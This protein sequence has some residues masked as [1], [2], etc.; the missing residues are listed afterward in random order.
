[1]PKDDIVY[2]GHMLD[3]TRKAV[4][5]VAGRSMDDFE[6]DE[7][8]RLVVAHLIQTIGE[9]AA[10]VSPA[11]RQAI[12]RFRGTRS[13]AFGTTSFMATCLSTGGFSGEL[14]PVIYRR[15]PKHSNE[16]C[17]RMSRRSTRPADEFPQALQ[18]QEA[19][20]ICDRDT[21]VS[22]SRHQRAHSPDGSQSCGSAPGCRSNPRISA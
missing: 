11:M 12:Q 16:L 8:L 10:P 21:S 22:D 13:S 19:S 14:R 20:A 4:A 18:Y 7:D 17:R 3:M 6:V 1:M 2:L 5:R 15:S 9:A